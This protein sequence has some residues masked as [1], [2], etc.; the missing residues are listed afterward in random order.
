MGGAYPWQGKHRQRLFMLRERLPHAVLLSGPRGVGKHAL[1]LDWGQ[2]LLC[3]APL[4]SGE[5][6]GACQ[7][8]H[9]FEIGNHPD[10]RYVTLEEKESREGGVKLASEISVEQARGAIEFAQL[11]AYRGGR[12]IICVHP[13]DSLNRAAGNALLKV[14]E[15]PPLNTLFILISHQARRL[16]PTIRSRCHRV[17]IGL[18][19]QNA[20]IS[21]LKKQEAGEP[22]AMLA[23]AGG[24]PI[25]ALQWEDEGAWTRRKEILAALSAPKELDAQRWGED[26]GRLSGGLWYDVSYK[27]LTDLLAVATGQQVR[28]NQ[29]HV[30]AL[31]RLADMLDL[32]RLLNLGRRHAEDGRWVEHPLNRPL[33]IESWLLE[34]RAIF[35]C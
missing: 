32:R 15:E 16:L 12:R 34:Y 7:A 35:Y 25:A 2:S 27:W 13:A 3:E 5:A 22:E 30:S 31:N 19:D 8:C 33:Q 10:W 18:P 29:D 23:Q 24:S 9:W 17:E 6:C 26:W 11:S 21:W 4:P 28:F 1:A 14:L 20:A